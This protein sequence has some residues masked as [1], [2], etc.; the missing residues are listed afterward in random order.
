MHD[1]LL[2]MGRARHSRGLLAVAAAATAV[3][4]FAPSAHA[5][6]GWTTG[7]GEG[8]L[9]DTQNA[10]AG[11]L[12]NLTVDLSLVDTPVDVA[13]R[14]QGYDCGGSI[15]EVYRSANTVEG[16]YSWYCDPNYNSYDIGFYL[17]QHRYYGP[18]DLDSDHAKSTS[19][20]T[21]HLG[22]LSTRCR[23]GHWQYRQEASGYVYPGYSANA[24]YHP[25]AKSHWVYFDC[26]SVD[27]APDL[28]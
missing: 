9:Q 10:Q 22:T 3:A 23:S 2:R 4:L 12:E 15:Y 7:T 6:G 13:Q 25:Y 20:K 11:A 27:E 18:K 26:G 17:Q 16:E 28:T 5:E 14:G 24:E 1:R 8:T 19:G 21:A